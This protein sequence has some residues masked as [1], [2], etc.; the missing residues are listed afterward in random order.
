M[1]PVLGY[2]SR[3]AAV[4]AM[5]EQ[6]ISTIDIAKRIG[7]PSNLVAGIESSARRNHARVNGNRTVLFSVEVLD[8]LA[9]HAA[10]R[11]VSANALARM[12]VETVVDAK[13]VDAV[14][15]D[16]GDPK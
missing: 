1:K 8:A 14:L 7:I 11:S 10:R 2:P 4:L 12:I 5:R 6:N 13:I 3:T 9:P 16:E 15:D